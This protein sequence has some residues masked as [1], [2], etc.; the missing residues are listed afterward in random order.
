MNGVTP[1]KFIVVTVPT[2]ERSGVLPGEYDSI[3][4][5]KMAILKM[6]NDARARGRF[7]GDPYDYWSVAGPM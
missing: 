5:A 2:G 4:D 3:H 6:A 7:T 1:G